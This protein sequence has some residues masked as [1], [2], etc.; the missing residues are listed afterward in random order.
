V[1]DG[2]GP[3]SALAALEVALG[4]RFADAALA[5]TA[6]AH[7][8]F[9]HESED[10]ASNERLE[11]LGDAVLGLVVADELYRAHPDWAEGELTRARA[12]LVNGAAL[13][14]CARALGLG[15][16]VRLGRTEQ[17][18][19]GADKDRILANCFEAVVGAVYVDG[20]MAP[21]AALARRAIGGEPEL[22]R[23]P[24]TAFQEWAHARFRTTPT[25]RMARDSGVE[26]DDARFTVEV[27]IG[28][29]TWGSG[30]G[31]SKRLAERHAAEQALVRGADADG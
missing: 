19:G 27:C 29:E 9:S 3:D 24:K 2:A 12:A 1:S 26:D 13:A 23:D 10:R 25:Y 21:A 22:A 17:R 16:H 5:A 18:S 7:A 30:S 14:R 8:S 20:G 15:A 4:Y 11:F 28:P 6:I 31:R